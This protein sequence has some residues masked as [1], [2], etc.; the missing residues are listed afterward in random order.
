VTITFEP[1]ECASCTAIVPIPP[2]PPCTRTV[3]SG[4]SPAIMN[5]FDHTVAATS[6][7][8]PAVTRS[9]PLGTGISWPAGTS[10][11]SAYPP[12]ESS[13]QTSSPTAQPSTPGPT[14]AT[15]PEHSSPRTSLAPGGGG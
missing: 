8:A 7:S 5:K 13:A 6:G 2:P 11:F 15:T 10:T 12:P 4:R 14:A 9:M 1:R 3:S